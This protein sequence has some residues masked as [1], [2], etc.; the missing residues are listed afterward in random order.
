MK[1]NEEIFASPN[2]IFFI[3]K[4]ISFEELT[5]KFNSNWE[6]DIDIKLQHAQAANQTFIS[7]ITEPLPFRSRSCSVF[8]RSVPVPFPFLFGSF[9]VPFPFLFRYIPVSFS[10]HLHSFFVQLPFH[11]FSVPFLLNIRNSSVFFPF[12]FFWNLIM[13]ILQFNSIAVLNFCI[14]DNGEMIQMWRYVALFFLTKCSA[15]LVNIFIFY[16]PHCITI[17]H[18]FWGDKWPML[19]QQCAVWQ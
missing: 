9:S 6:F 18:I 19:V 4:R 13:K 10:F 17:W 15:S 16:A 14:S 1:W 11:F 5:E 7:F 12:P 3:L 8:D 2:H